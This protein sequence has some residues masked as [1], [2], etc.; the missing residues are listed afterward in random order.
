MF[1]VPTVFSSSVKKPIAAIIKPI[2]IKKKPMPMIASIAPTQISVAAVWNRLL[3]ERSAK[4]WKQFLIYR[5]ANR[6]KIKAIIKQIIT[7]ATN[8]M[9]PAAIAFVP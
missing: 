9:T 7:T 6:S 1:P 5:T 3:F 4:A 2:Q 8:P